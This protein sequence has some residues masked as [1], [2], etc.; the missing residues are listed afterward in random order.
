MTTL[1]QRPAESWTP[2]TFQGHLDYLQRRHGDVGEPILDHPLNGA[3]TSRQELVDYITAVGDLVDH[4]AGK[5]ADAC[6][7]QLTEGA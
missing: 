7:V 5:H 6:P 1:A 2:C 4:L 3:L